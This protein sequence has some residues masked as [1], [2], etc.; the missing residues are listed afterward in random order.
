[1]AICMAI[2]LYLSGS[3]AIYLSGSICMAIYLSVSI[4]LYLYLSIYGY[5]ALSIYLSVSIYLSIYLYLYLSIYLSISLSI[6]LYTHCI[7]YYTYNSYNN[8][9]M[10][11]NAWAP[12]SDSFRNHPGKSARSLFNLAHCQARINGR[13]CGGSPLVSLDMG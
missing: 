2:W 4:Y 6:Y 7:S 13:G 10:L 12:G 3:M 8:M 5:L 1:M 9:L 11:V